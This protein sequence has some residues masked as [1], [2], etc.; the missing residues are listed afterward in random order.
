MYCPMYHPNVIC[1]SDG[2]EWK[3]SKTIY[4]GKWKLLEIVS[5][6][7]KSSS[8][9][10]FN[11]V[12]MPTHHVLSNLVKYQFLLIFGPTRELIRIDLQLK[13][14]ILQQN[15]N[16]VLRSQKLLMYRCF[17]SQSWF[18]PEWFWIGQF[19]DSSINLDLYHFCG[20]SCF[21]TD[22][23]LTMHKPNSIDWNWIL[24]KC[25]FF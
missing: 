24:I 4:R 2:I 17:V 13:G 23:A 11:G 25:C 16:T 5:N 12:L 21:L 14:L 3:N 6:M 10:F 19:T 20:I 8:L 15:M 7:Q 1:S 22:K 18:I 9:N